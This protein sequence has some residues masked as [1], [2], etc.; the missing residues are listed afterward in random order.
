MKKYALADLARLLDAELV[1]ATQ[2]FDIEG[3][4]SIDKAGPQ[5]ITFFASNPKYQKFLATTQAG[6]VLITRDLLARCSRN[7]LVV[8]DPYVA[9]AKVAALFEQAPQ[10]VIGIHPSAIIAPDVKV[11]ASAS[12]GPFVVISAGVLLGERVVIG[13]HCVIDEQCVIGADSELKP[14]VTLYHKV[15]MG[16]N[17]LIHSGAVLGSD[18]FGNAKEHD[19]W[20]KIPQL[21]GVVLGDDVEIGANTTIDRG[22]VEDTRIGNNVR[23]DNQV[24][25]AHNVVVGDG[26]AMAAQVGIAGSAE[27]G[28]ACLLAGKVGVNGHIKL[29]DQVVVL[30]MSGV[31]NDLDEAGVYSAAIPA[32]PVLQW[33]KTMVRLNR[34]EA[35]VEKVKLIWKHLGLKE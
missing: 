33:N 12:I 6:V 13:A 31:A 5:H 9:F 1:L 16:Q 2:A 24:Q 23:I 3:L 20:I 32:R 10:A 7:A 30:A 22:A 27:I 19:R 34:L 28:R 8:K 21:G 18:G 25:I 11:P 14:R 26:V 15:K 17:C 29:A 4:A 35:L